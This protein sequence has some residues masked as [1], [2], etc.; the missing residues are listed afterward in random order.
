[1][2]HALKSNWQDSNPNSASAWSGQ[3]LNIAEPRFSYLRN[4]DDTASSARGWFSF[5]VC[6]FALYIHYVSHP[7]QRSF[8][9]LH[10]CLCLFWFFFKVP[11]E[12]SL[13]H[14]LRITNDYGLLVPKCVPDGKCSRGGIARSLLLYPNGGCLDSEGRDF[15]VQKENWKELLKTWWNCPLTPPN[16]S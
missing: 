13:V 12:L 16:E 11:S 5:P 15:P 9:C 3:V 7:S 8:T 6:S 4:G 10:S 1:M 14:V 2:A